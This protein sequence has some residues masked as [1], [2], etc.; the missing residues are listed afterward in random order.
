MKDQILSYL[1]EKGYS[2]ETICKVFDYLHDLVNKGDLV[3]PGTKAALCAAGRAKLWSDYIDG[4]LGESL[5]E[6]QALQEEIRKDHAIVLN[7]IATE[8]LALVDAQINADLSKTST[9][10]D[11]RIDNLET[12]F[13]NGFKGGSSKPSRMGGHATYEELKEAMEEKRQKRG[14]CLW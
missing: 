9:A 11:R 6:L 13:R 10:L 3:A 2:Q 7:G 12:A 14:R 5:R 1:K 4:T 8:E